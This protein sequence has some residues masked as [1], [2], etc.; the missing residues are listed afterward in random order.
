LTSPPAPAPQERL[1]LRAEYLF[2]W[3]KDSPLRVP[4]VFT[5]PSSVG[6]TLAGVTPAL[7]AALL[8]NEDIDAGTH[9]GG[10][11]MAGLWLDSHNVIGL[12]AGYF[13]LADHTTHQNVPTPVQP[14]QAA[15]AIPIVDAAADAIGPT[16]VVPLALPK[17]IGVLTLTSSLQ[18]A[19][20][21]MVVKL[22]SS[23]ELR[24]EMLSGFRYLDLRENLSLTTNPIGIGVPGAPDGPALALQTTAH[25]EAES[26]FYGWQLGARAE[27]HMGPWFANG[28]VKVALGDMNER[29][30]IG[31]A[32][33]PAAIGAALE[34]LSGVP[35]TSLVQTPLGKSLP[36]GAFLLGSAAPG[37]SLLPTPLGQ[38][39]QGATA[40]VLPTPLGSTLLGV[41]RPSVAGGIVLPPPHRESHFSRDRLTLV[42]EVG[43]N[44]G[45]QFTDR[46]R[47]F[48]G[49]DFLYMTSV[50][51]PGNPFEREIVVN[52]ALRT[53]FPGNPA[54]PGSPLMIHVTGSEFW[55]QGIH[56][57]IEYRY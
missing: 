2:W 28:V 41:I 26:Q 42:P 11:F 23:P 5:V 12:E 38:S 36:V 17:D 33:S 46:L 44:L 27:Y 6:P 29:V 34:G 18:G 13:F 30:G 15:L 45:Y 54:G 31:A 16:A 1:W 52:Q 21:N 40:V 10:R 50:V 49:Y 4:L 57:G 19:E 35:G 7:T 43:V 3:F 14:I 25:S 24:V 22:V 32:V 53:V 51:R 39:L 56:A 20:A 9:H 47:A 55:A 8:G 37:T 48:F